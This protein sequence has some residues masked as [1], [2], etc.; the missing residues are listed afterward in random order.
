MTVKVLTGLAW[1]VRQRLLMPLGQELT[2]ILL[3]NKKS[4]LRKWILRREPGV[5]L[6]NKTWDF[7][8]T[9]NNA[10]PLR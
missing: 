5:S 3:E 2:E 4:W 1:F 6:S 8:M 7:R 10:V 9:Q